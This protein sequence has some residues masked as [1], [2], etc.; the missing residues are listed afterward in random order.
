MLIINLLE[1][2]IKQETEDQIKPSKVWLDSKTYQQLIDEIFRNVAVDVDIT[3]Q[4][5]LDVDIVVIPYTNLRII[6][7]FRGGTK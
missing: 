2:L 7:M 1:K 4:Q 5:F 6:K 3:L